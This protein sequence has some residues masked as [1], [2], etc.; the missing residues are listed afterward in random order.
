M[1]T[2]FDIDPPVLKELKRLQKVEGK[3]LGRLASELLAQ[4][5]AD[6]RKPKA[7]VGFRWI[8]RRMGAKVE[9]ADKEAIYQWMRMTCGEFCHRRQYTAPRI[10][11]G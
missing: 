9:L 3:S 5:L 11:R 6:R 2:T 4:A 8:S 7:V 10:G 1:R